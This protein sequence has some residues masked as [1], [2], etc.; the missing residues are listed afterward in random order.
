LEENVF[1]Q[2]LT[3]VSVKQLFKPKEEEPPEPKKT[4]A[5]TKKEPL[6]S[7]IAALSA[8]DEEILNVVM[9]NEPVKVNLTGISDLHLILELSGRDASELDNEEKLSEIMSFVKRYKLTPELLIELFEL[10]IKSLRAEQE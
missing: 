1:N 4:L 8:S 2:T 9:G 10:C 5:E 7:K 3:V 6:A